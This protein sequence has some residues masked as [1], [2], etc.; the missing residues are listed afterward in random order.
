MTNDEGSSNDRMS[1]W[2]PQSST[3]DS[4]FVI[5]SSLDIRHS[6]LSQS[7][8]ATSSQLAELLPIIERNAR[9]AVDT[10][11]DSL[12]CYREILR[13]RAGQGFAKSK[14]GLAP[15]LAENGS[16]CA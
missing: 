4:D 5:P 7:L 9:V 6:S 16:V 12:H 11:A 13:D 15:P 10:E 14:L 8:I 1:K 3:C 2:P